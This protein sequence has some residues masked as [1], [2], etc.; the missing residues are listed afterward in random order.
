MSP[1]S[2]SAV[3]HPTGAL[4]RRL[5]AAAWT[6]LQQHLAAAS[7]KKLKT[8]LRSF[9][10]FAAAVPSRQLF[11]TPTVHGEVAPSVHNE[12]TMILYAEYMATRPS[13]VHGKPVKVRTIEEYVSMVKAHLSVEYGFELLG[14]PQRLRRLLKAMRRNEGLS[15]ERRKRRALRRRHLRR[16]WRRSQTLRGTERGVVNGMAAVTAAWQALARGGEACPDGGARPTRA[17]LEWHR[18]RGYVVWHL[19]PIK[20]RDGGVAEKVPVIIAKHRGGG[21]DAYKMLDRL[22]KLDPVPE[23]ARASTPLFRRGDKRPMRMRDFRAFVKRIAGAAGL[24]AG[25][26]GGHSAR[27][28]GATDLVAGGA[29]PLLLQAKGRWASDI[30]R[31]YARL[32]RRTQL[33]ASRSR[34][35]RLPRPRDPP[36][37]VAS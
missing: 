5:S 29:S 3:E 25:E 22:E 37:S 2:L 1:P 32:T 8:A 13:P 33:Q 27:I 14:T 15:G 18:E 12:W 36:H 35:P 23:A 34:T 10:E 9:A 17:D 7:R 11:V 30:G 16:A 6:H 19:R 4:E 26:F 24:P 21:A 28:G 20:Q 31:I